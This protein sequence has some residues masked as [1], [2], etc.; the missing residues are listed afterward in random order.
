M[1]IIGLECELAHPSDVW[2]ALAFPGMDFGP[3]YF[4]VSDQSLWGVDAPLPDRIAPD[5]FRKLDP[6]C[7]VRLVLHLYPEGEEPREIDTYAEYCASPCEMM[8][9]VYD[10]CYLE[11]YCKN[12][13]WLRQVFQMVRAIPGAKVE[14]KH[15]GSDSRYRMYV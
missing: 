3:R 12:P 8:A 10:S 4:W 1:D 11:L 15:E 9:L 13:H 14:E 2:K 5:G 7:A 6:G